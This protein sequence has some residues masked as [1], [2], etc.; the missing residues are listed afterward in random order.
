[1]KEEIVLVF[2]KG[3]SS[4]LFPSDL[5]LEPKRH[6]SEYEAIKGDWEKVGK[7][8]VFASG[9]VSDNKEQENLK[10]EQEELAHS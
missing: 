6:F 5:E 10:S 7:Y 2:V 1:M 9:S 8:L 3:L 4:I